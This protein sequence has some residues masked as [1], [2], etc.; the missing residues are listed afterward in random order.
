MMEF[1]FMDQHPDREHNRQDEHIELRLPTENDMG[2]IRWLWSDPETMK[3]VGGPIH[4]TDEQAQ[5]WFAEMIEPGDPADCYRLIFN[6]KDEPVGEISFH[7]LDPASMT[8]EFNIKIASTKRGKGYA[9]KAMLLF[10]DFFFNQVGGRI[11]VDD[12]ALDNRRGQHVLLDFG[13]EH[14]PKIDN[15]FQLF[16]TRERYN[17][18]YGFRGLMG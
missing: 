18:L 4:L 16:L 1:P 11:M 13:F 17:S 12:V 5:H 3:P 15:V 8:A 9:K 6:G 14:D 10:L 2:F 7:R